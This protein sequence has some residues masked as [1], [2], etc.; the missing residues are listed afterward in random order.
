MPD[1]AIYAE[2]ALQLWRDASLPVFSG[3]GAGYGVLY[4]L[5]AGLPLTVGDVAQGYAL[6][7]PLQALV[8]SLAAV[9][10]FFYGRRLMSPGYALVATALT[11]ASPLLLYSGFVMTEVLFYPLAA[12]ALLA[13]ARAVETATVKHQLVALALIGAAVATRSQAVVFVAVLAAAALLDSVLARDRSRLRLFWP[14]W[15]TLLAGVIA[16]AAAPGLLGSYAVTV[17]G[18]YPLV[19]S[20]RLAYHHLAY[21]AL[22]TA[23]L[24]FAA[25]AILL[26][27]AFRGRELDPAA[28]AFLLI[29]ACAVL[30]V[31][32]QVGFFAARFAPHLLGR[33]LASLPPPLFLAFALWLSRGASRPRRV[34]VTACFAVLALIA[35]AP[36]NGLIVTGALPDSFDA[37]LAYRLRGSVDVASLVTLVSL[38]LLLVFAVIPRRVALVL[39][40][41]LIALLAASSVSASRLIVARAGADQHELLGSPRDW[42][43]RAATS[44]VTYL[45]DGEPAWNGVWQ[46]RFWNN[47]IVHVLTLPPA[48]VP[49]PMPQRAHALAPDGHVA[50][51]DL[52]VVAT[53]RFSFFGTPV[54]HQARGLELHGLTLWR[55]AV[56]PRLSMLTTGIL[57]NGDMTGPGTIVVYNCAGGTLELT[58]LPKA[59]EVVRVSLDDVR[60][61]RRRIAGRLSWHGSIRV[62]ATHTKTCRFTIRGGLLLGS[63]V[64]TF[65][66]P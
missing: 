14:T 2:R 48:R 52:Y 18:S 66:R 42:V 39:P 47:R 28:R 63:T 11:L 41:L 61:L 21:L 8:V 38:G 1:E 24:P 5:L 25:L 30:A 4:P 35:L 32:A 45:Y 6:L 58:R 10:V 65:E 53:D 36:W 27:D 20:L 34:V 31:C 59:T 46:Q 40:A 17:S 43:D 50:I 49:G 33:D 29:T 37:S 64:R 3:Q 57:P 56:R 9:P 60:V 15:L 62:P 51:Q 22:M 54:A 7:K 19:D 16:A 12:L 23:V 26:V 44:E 55:L 13:S